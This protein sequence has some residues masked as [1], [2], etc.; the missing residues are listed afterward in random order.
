MK[1]KTVYKTEAGGGKGGERIEKSRV[2]LAIAPARLGV[3]HG[4]G[5]TARRAEVD[6][7]RRRRRR[8]RRALRGEV[9]R[10][11]RGRRGRRRFLVSRASH[12][13]W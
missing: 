5:L 4:L 13:C 6:Q 2:L 8:Q 3:V 7:P 11:C 1:P 10:N 9:R 12:C